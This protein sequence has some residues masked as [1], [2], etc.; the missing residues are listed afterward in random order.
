M[1]FCTYFLFFLVNKPDLGGNSAAL[2]VK[3]SG[4]VLG[5]VKW[6]VCL[7]DRVLCSFGFCH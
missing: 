1:C 7:G 4:G 6:L 3:G 5:V 2:S